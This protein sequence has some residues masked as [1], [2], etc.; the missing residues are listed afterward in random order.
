VSVANPNLDGS[1][2]CDFCM[3][4]VPLLNVTLD[5][6]FYQFRVYGSVILS[7]LFIALNCVLEQGLR[8]KSCAL[9]CFYF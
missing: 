7:Y 8:V 9:K 2:T 6:E 4:R 3:T 5:A 1:I